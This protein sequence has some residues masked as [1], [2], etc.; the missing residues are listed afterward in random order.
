MR[1]ASRYYHYPI[2]QVVMGA[3]PAGLRRATR[4]RDEAQ[5]RADTDAAALAADWSTLPPRAVAQR[6]VLEHLRSDTAPARSSA[7]ARTCA[8][9]RRAQS[10]I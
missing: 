10:G 3:L 9:L 7:A 1:F 8:R 4:G 2:G 5:A 6:R